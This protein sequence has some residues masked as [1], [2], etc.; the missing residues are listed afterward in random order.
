[1]E[2]KKYKAFSDLNRRSCDALVLAYNPRQILDSYCDRGFYIPSCHGVEESYGV[3]L[4]KMFGTKEGSGHWADAVQ[5]ATIKSLSKL[6]KRIEEG[7][8]TVVSGDPDYQTIFE[9]HF[10]SFSGKLE[11]A[12]IYMK[13]DL[14]RFR[15]GKREQ[16]LDDFDKFWNDSEK[17]QWAQIHKFMREYTREEYKKKGN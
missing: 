3:A 6:E 4:R 16:A 11:H 1:M 13:G 9:G 8:W 15:K 10:S 7:V 14:Y 12:W 5:W 2:D 17:K